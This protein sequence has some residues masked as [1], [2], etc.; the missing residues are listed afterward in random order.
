[1]TD[2]WP[3]YSEGRAPLDYEWWTP[4]GLYYQGYIEGQMG[5]DIEDTNTE[6]VPE[7]FIRGCQDGYGDW[8]SGEN[9]KVNNLTR[10]PIQAGVKFTWASAKNVDDLFQTG[11][12]IYNIGPSAENLDQ[13][14]FIWTGDDTAPSEFWAKWEKT[15]RVER[16]VG[17]AW[18]RIGF[19]LI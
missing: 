18:R 9:A 16:G 2:N 11:D 5:R 17:V 14:E 10:G 4:A 3:I 1:L 13:S 8:I 7:E 12:I 19:S 6:A 15:D